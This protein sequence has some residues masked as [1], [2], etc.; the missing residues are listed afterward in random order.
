MRRWRRNGP[1]LR[2]CCRRG[3][4]RARRCWSS[5]R[6][7]RRRSRC[8]HRRGCRLYS[9][10]NRCY[11]SRRS[12]CRSASLAWHCR[13]YG[14]GLGNWRSRC[15][16]SLYWSSRNWCWRSLNRSRCWGHLSWGSSLCRRWCRNCLSWRWWGGL[17]RSRCWRWRS[18]L[19]LWDRRLY[20]RQ[21]G[22]IGHGPFL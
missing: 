21:G 14:R 4:L 12:N 9:R 18:R 6:R 15:S 8:S 20:W 7:Y 13:S 19:G 10:S 17:C 1:G 16:S 5:R 11:W 2:R 22:S 3:R